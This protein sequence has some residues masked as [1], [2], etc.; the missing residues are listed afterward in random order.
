MKMGID[1]RI[2]PTA[3]IKCPITIGNHV[4]IDIGVYISTTTIIGDYVHIAPYSC[5][6]GGIN[7]L[8]I[9]ED[10]TNLSVSSSIIVISDDFARGMINPIV[11]VKYRHLIGKEIIMRRFSTVGANSVVMPNVVM[12]EGSMLGANSLLSK[13]T[14]P[15]TIYSGHP[16]KA[17]MERD[18]ELVLRAYEELGYKY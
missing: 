18:K 8:F 11:P 17:I 5:I 1:V 4:S 13:S 3:R 6:I 10:F 7:G 12:A 9:M 16:A 14:R 15:W 2:D